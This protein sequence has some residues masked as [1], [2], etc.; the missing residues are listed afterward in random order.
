MLNS[1]KSSVTWEGN[2]ASSGVVVT[3]KVGRVGKSRWTS[4][5][6]ESESCSDVPRCALYL[7]TEIYR[8]GRSCSRSC[9]LSSSP[10]PYHHALTVLPSAIP[11]GMV[12]IGSGIM[13][14]EFVCHSHDKFVPF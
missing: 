5:E 3:C 4:S 8:A 10:L 11:E 12:D 2:L 6:S 14:Q 9:A 7:D 13:L 1:L